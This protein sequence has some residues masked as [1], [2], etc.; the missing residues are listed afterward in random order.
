M[1]YRLRKAPKRDLYW[2][3]GIDGTK[4]SKDPLPRDR[5]EAQM[6]ALY[7]NMKKKGLRKSG[8]SG[9]GVKA[10]A[11]APASVAKVALS[12]EQT[13]QMIDAYIAMREVSK[14]QKQR[15]AIETQLEFDL[16]PGL[17][18]A[19]RKADDI[20][21]MR[22]N[23][24]A[25]TAKIKKLRAIHGFGRLRGGSGE[26]AQLKILYDKVKRGMEADLNKR[27]LGLL[28]RQTGMAKIKKNMALI[29]VIVKKIASELPKEVVEQISE[30]INAPWLQAGTFILE[31]TPEAKKKEIFENFEPNVSIELLEEIINS[32]EE[33]QPLEAPAPPPPAPPAPP[34]PPPPAPAVNRPLTTAEARKEA[35]GY[36]KHLEGS[37]SRP[38]NNIL[39]QIAKASYQGSAPNIIGQYRLVFSTSTL[40]IYKSGNTVVVGIRGTVPTDLE[41]VKADGL[42]ALNRLE[43]SPRYKRDLADLQRFRTQN[44]NDD[45]Y[46]VGHSLGGAI[47]DALLHARLLQSGV[48]YNPA[49]QPKDF[50]RPVANHRIYNKGD[51]LYN[52]GKNFIQQQSEVRPERQKSFAER[53]VGYIPYAGQAYDYLNAH[54]LDNFEGGG[55]SSEASTPAN[56]FK[57]Q[58]EKAGLEPSSY[59]AEAR[60]RAKEHHYPYKLLGFAKDGEHKLVIPDGNG[61]LV[62]FGRVGYGDHII[63]SHLEKHHKVPSGT[64]DAKRNTF[65]KSHKKIRGDWASKPFSP[66]NLALRISW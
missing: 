14:L 45:Y 11:S 23:I 15:K 57:T 33:P 51:P 26:T 63:Y 42:V 4:H 9:K 3:V 16:R 13:Q 62:A 1:P 58:L 27:N 50:N 48:S 20:K 54:A 8:G 10:S 18:D 44:P 60:R 49:V 55:K 12:K 46:G 35:Y 19:H 30:V 25:L 21:V 22:E 6:R 56:P 59:L 61:R 65:Q 7:A 37:G 34:P 29:E 32:V 41:D 38:S 17:N 5:A 47:L 64:A 40:K 66:N 39:H 28:R 31:S 53:L 24:E 2:V 36:G 52:L 43:T